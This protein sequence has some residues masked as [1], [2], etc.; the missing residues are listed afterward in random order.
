MAFIVQGHTFSGL[1]TSLGQLQSHVC[2][3]RNDSLAKC[4]DRC[5][6][7]LIRQIK[8][9]PIPATIF[10]PAVTSYAS[11]LTPIPPSSDYIESGFL[12]SRLYREISHF[13]KPQCFLCQSLAEPNVIPIPEDLCLACNIKI[14]KGFANAAE[15]LPCFPIDLDQNVHTFSD[16]YNSLINL[17]DQSCFK[18]NFSVARIP[19]KFE[20]LCV[21]CIINLVN[22]VPPSAL[23]HSLTSYDSIGLGSLYST[24]YIELAQLQH[25]QCVKCQNRLS[26]NV[27]PPNSKDL[28]LKCNI[29]LLK[30]ILD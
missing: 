25:I 1:Y 18:C 4:E 20:E 10:I 13:Q 7:C 24:L 29:Q 2:F 16:F 22:P 28:C 14:L 23:A 21:H 27:L 19:F 15:P 12:F 30:S 6:N 26:T 5:V 3:G 8:L 9:S 17:Q 11:A